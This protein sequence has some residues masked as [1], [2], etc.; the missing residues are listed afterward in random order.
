[1]TNEEIQE[2]ILKARKAQSKQ[3]TIK[4]LEGLIGDIIE[5]DKPICIECGCSTIFIKDEIEI[6][7]DLA[8][9]LNKM[10]ET[11]KKEL[12]EFH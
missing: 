1:M 7:K 10:L 8:K 3:T 5:S 9:I 12:E 11:T 2:L 4:N 6:R